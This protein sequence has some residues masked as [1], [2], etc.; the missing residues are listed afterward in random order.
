MRIA[1]LVKQIPKFEE[2]ELGPDGRLK[3]DGIELELNPYCRRAVS[4]GVELAATRPGSSVTVVTLGP[5]SA[6]DSLREAIAW[7]A[8]REVDTTGVLVTDPAFAGS[9]TLATAK[10][11]AAALGR[12]GPFDLVLTGRNSVDADT[13][14]VAP[15][16]AYLCD[17]PFLSGVRHLAID[18]DLVC[19][20][21][22]HD[23]GWLQA[24]VRLPAILSCAER[25]IDPA[26]VEPPERA[27]VPADRIRR[28]TAAEL[29]PGPWGAAAS[30]T[31][32]GHV[33][34]M[35]VTRA[36]H[37]DA[38]APVADQARAAVRT[39]H[40]RGALAETSDRSGPTRT[41]APARPGQPVTMVV[42][43]PDRAHDTRELLGAAAALTGNVLVTVCE[44]PDRRA[45]ERVGRGRDRAPRLRERRR[46]GRSRRNGTRAR[47]SALGDSHRFDGVGPRSRLTRRRRARRGPHRRRGRARTGHGPPRRVEAGLRR[48]ARCRDPLLVRR[49]DGHRARRSAAH[50]GTA[51]SHA[52]GHGRG[53]IP[54][55]V[56][57]R[58][59]HRV[60]VLA[61]TRDDDLDVLAEAHTVIGIG[62]GVAP[63]A[64]DELEPLRTMLDAQLGATRKVTDKGWQPRSRQIGITGRSIAPRLFVSIGA[65][66]KFNH[67]VGLRAAGDGAGDQRRS[68][69]ADLRLRR[70]R[71]RRR[72]ARRTAA[73]RRAA[74]RRARLA[75]R[76][77]SA[78]LGAGGRQNVTS[79]AVA[80]PTPATNTITSDHQ[81]CGA[82]SI[83]WSSDQRP[84]PRHATASR[85]AKRFMRYS[86]PSVGR[87]KTKK[88]ALR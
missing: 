25:L 5:P 50:T 86:Q 47:D 9:D 13:G 87:R 31:S 38:D 58:A 54:P 49:A 4:Q 41:V 64:Y 61:R 56:A 7:G 6:E 79:V 77:L 34:V 30:P 16:L 10:A 8:R 78:G 18:G 27:A 2:M 14:Q 24:E 48:S 3:R 74:P 40:E 21:C 15:Q 44:S 22:E 73:P 46:R 29:G 42:A 17:L 35:A 19:A 39:L 76:Q 23:D 55:A 52:C 85:A 33:K 36:R 72:L 82:K 43:E 63:D 45:T 88:P 28:L 68:R 51:G 1:V 69:R 60:R 67:S 11:L 66:G 80:P 83:A 20:R 75:T 84:G 70:R 65:S 26:K 71:D 53:R 32:V 62:Q 81:L 37:V 59:R 57:P 12:E